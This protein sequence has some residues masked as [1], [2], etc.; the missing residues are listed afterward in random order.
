MKPKRHSQLKTKARKHMD[1]GS[2]IR[3][4]RKHI[5]THK[6][7]HRTLS[8]LKEIISSNKPNNLNEDA[9]IRSYSPQALG[10][11]RNMFLHATA[12]DGD[13]FAAWVRD[14]LYRI[15]YDNQ[16]SVSD[17]TPKDIEMGLNKWE[18]SLRQ[19]DKEFG[20]YLDQFRLYSHRFMDVAK[21]LMNK[22]DESLGVKPSK[23]PAPSV[24]G[25]PSS[26]KLLRYKSEA[27]G[28]P[29]VGTV[30]PF[31][32]KSIDGLQT[33]AGK[34]N[35]EGQPQV[36]PDGQS[37]SPEQAMMMQDPSMGMGFTPQDEMFLS[38]IDT[39]QS[40][41]ELDDENFMLHVEDT[42]LNSQTDPFMV[43]Q[44]QLEAMMNEDFESLMAQLP[45]ESLIKNS[46]DKFEQ[47]FEK[48][49]ARFLAFA[50]K[51]LQKVKEEELKGPKQFLPIVKYNI[52]DVETAL[53]YGFIS[54][55][56]PTQPLI[57]TNLNLQ[58]LNALKKNPGLLASGRQMATNLAQM[59]PL[60]SK[61]FIH[62]F[63]GVT[64]ES[65]ISEDWPL[66]NA[67]SNT[68]II[69]QFPTQKVFLSR[70][71]LKTCP[72]GTLN[73]ECSTKIKSV[74][75]V[76][77]VTFPLGPKQESRIQLNQSL[78]SLHKSDYIFDTPYDIQKRL[79]MHGVEET[80]ARQ[81]AGTIFN[82]KQAII[83]SLSTFFMNPISGILNEKYIT[84]SLE[85]FRKESK[86]FV[87]LYFNEFKDLISEFLCKNIKGDGKF[88]SGSDALPNSIIIGNSFGN[89]I[90]MLPLNEEIFDNI[91]NMTKCTVKT[92]DN[93]LSKQN[94]LEKYFSKFA[95]SELEPETIIQKS[96]KERPFTINIL[97]QMIL[98]EIERINAMM[99]SGLNVTPAFHDMLTEEIQEYLDSS[100]RYASFSFSN[101]IKFFDI[102]LEG[103]KFEPVNIYEILTQENINKEKEN[104]ND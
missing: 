35:S 98:P 29:G 17:F 63:A 44:E 12:L 73:R 58:K 82:H 100:I 33:G 66:Y 55:V 101:F 41:L 27:E 23:A 60:I 64:E 80:I 61:S 94:Y 99:N 4:R 75:L 91:A 92:F 43:S 45:P 53:I 85:R 47:L 26:P 96:L 77:E 62:A 9:S 46:P 104:E 20:K 48:Y 54:S 21:A 36:G 68:N 103:I 79:T 56:N 74:L 39:M 3:K 78:M 15:A 87:E 88:K 13:A 49:K 18:D 51:T 1:L 7:K 6:G 86:R 8:E 38:Y 69:F 50:E 102:E 81:Q 90:M 84:D 65:E 52:S 24:E 93:K 70:N 31:G 32:T 57:A 95:A 5:T 11:K 28:G 97:Y 67:Y 30:L 16:K 40:A 14:R 59:Y 89:S 42:I 37:I 10:R 72:E 2:N 34:G 22:G 71:K 25:A 76:D 19:G 83:D